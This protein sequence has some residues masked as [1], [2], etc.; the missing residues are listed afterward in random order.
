MKILKYAFMILFGHAFVIL[1]TYYTYPA[2]IDAFSGDLSVWSVL[3]GGFLALVL[4]VT[5]VSTLS[6][7]L[8]WYL[9]F[10]NSKFRK[11]LLKDD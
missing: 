2:L 5:T 10:F 7:C 1:L 6:F 8:V 11:A 3:Y 9:L 4:F